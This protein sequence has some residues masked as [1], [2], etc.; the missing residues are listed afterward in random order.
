MS[1]SEQKTK[2]FLNNVTKGGITANKNLWTFIKPFLTNKVCLVNK[3]ITLI[4]GNKF[5]AN[6]RELSKLS[7]NI[8]TLFRSS[9]PEVFCKKVFL[10]ISQNSQEN[11]CARV[12]FFIRLQAE[13][14]NFI[15][16]ENLT[17]VFSYEFCENFNN[18]FFT[19]HLRC[20]FLIVKK[21]SGKN[22]KDISQRD[23]NQNIQKLI[24]EIVKSYGT[25]LVYCK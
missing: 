16:K 4:E 12:S 5:T 19:E 24:R 21:S 18:T 7:K 10:K 3:D 20:L 23:K 11:I 1:H 25:I 14:C 13:A 6:K 8:L 15:K 17:Q 9:R 2:S 22:P